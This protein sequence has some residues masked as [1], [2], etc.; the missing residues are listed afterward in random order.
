MLV[1]FF[2][3]PLQGALFRKFRDVILGYAHIDTLSPRPAS[4]A[5]ERVGEPTDIDGPTETDTNKPT[6]TETDV[7]S[8][9]NE[10]AIK[11]TSWADIV[12]R[13]PAAKHTK[14]KDSNANKA[15]ILKKQSS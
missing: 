12:S 13:T 7:S 2:T 8:K 14:R 5:E 10:V 15:L 3:K 6:E 11:Q 4:A 9:E 1:D